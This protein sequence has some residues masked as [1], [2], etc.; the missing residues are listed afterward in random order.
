MKLF[1]LL[2]TFVLATFSVAVHAE[3]SGFYPAKAV[4]GSNVKFVYKNPRPSTHLC[5]VSGLPG[6]SSNHIFSDI[7]FNLI[8][9]KTIKARVHCGFYGPIPPNPDPVYYQEIITDLQFTAA[10]VITMSFPSGIYVGMKYPLKITHRNTQSCALFM[11]NNSYP[12]VASV[13][14]SYEWNYEWSNGAGTTQA[15]HLKC[16][17]DDGVAVNTTKSFTLTAYPG[18]PKAPQITHFGHGNL[19][20]GNTG[21]YWSTQNVSQCKLSGMGITANVSTSGFGYNVTVPFGNTKFTLA[22]SNGA[23]T[24]TKDLVVTRQSLP[25]S[26][27]G[28]GGGTQPVI[29]LSDLPIEVM[30][31]ENN[32][33]I[34]EQA[35]ALDDENHQIVRFY[36]PDENVQGVLVIDRIKNHV[37]AYLYNE[38]ENSS[39]HIATIF[40]LLDARDIDSIVYDTETKAVSIVL[41][42]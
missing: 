21:L 5:S 24:V 23:K 42:K 35:Q 10:P 36:T 30:R 11:G 3:E 37:D 4:E 13:P 41:K 28:G 34:F 25:G 18:D 19:N 2:L 38:Y 29:E 31:K 9:S 22:C 40:G 16:I 15:F 12:T 20:Q 32:V 7:S 17:G 27:G 33:S 26:G 8:A 6:L 1:F 39:E 14:S